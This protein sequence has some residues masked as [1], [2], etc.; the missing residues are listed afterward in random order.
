[1]PAPAP[2]DDGRPEHAD[3]KDRVQQARLGRQEFPQVAER[4]FPGLPH[5]R[6]AGHVREGN[7][8]VLHIPN[9]HR[10][11]EEQVQRQRPVRPG[12]AQLLAGRGPQDEE[13]R[14]AK[15]LEQ[16]RVFAE[17][18]QAHPKPYPEPITSLRVFLDRPPTRQHGQRPE[19]HRQGIDRHEHRADRHERGGGSNQQQEEPG[20]G[21]DLSG[22]EPEQDAAE[23]G[24]DDGGEKAHAQRSIAPNRGAQKLRIS[25]Q[26][27][28][29]V[30]GQGQVLGPQPL[31]RFVLA[32]LDG[33]AG[34]IRQ[35]RQ[36]QHPKPDAADP[37]P[38]LVQRDLRR[39]KAGLRQPFGGRKRRGLLFFTLGRLRAH[40]RNQ[41]RRHPGPPKRKP[42]P[43]CPAPE[44]VERP[45][46]GG[47]IAG[48]QDGSG[49][50]I[51]RIVDPVIEPGKTDQDRQRQHEPK[52]APIIN[53]GHHCRG[54]PIGRVGGGHAP[55]A[56][57]GVLGRALCRWPGGFH[58]RRFPV[59]VR[60]VGTMDPGRTRKGRGRLT[61]C[62]MLRQMNPSPMARTAIAI[63]RQTVPRTRPFQRSSPATRAS[64]GRKQRLPLRKGMTTSKTGF[65]NRRL[66]KR[67][68]SMSSVW[69]QCIR[70]T[71]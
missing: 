42:F 19:Q 48:A 65:A 34:N 10:H 43:A 62:L 51:A 41:Q 69:S 16:R 49:R 17:E 25:N 6:I 9:H 28:F 56:R 60:P 46:D 63:T 33:A 31:I 66:T 68:S 59:A 4:R 29:A 38:V 20:A 70:Q 32:Q 37:Q 14:P 22:E 15:P 36:Q 23:N 55:Q 52:A 64:N 53:E 67:N 50:R 45:H 27:R 8:V 39:T 3:E 61:A 11:G 24:G 1:M 35:A 13:N 26:R 40:C 21:V 47:G 44:R 54:E 57:I 58:A 2:E 71:V 18:P 7:P 12:A 5:M 30:I